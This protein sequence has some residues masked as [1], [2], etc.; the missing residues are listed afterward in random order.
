M[1]Y[2]L[3]AMSQASPTGL[4][5]DKYGRSIFICQSWFVTGLLLDPP[6]R[7]RVA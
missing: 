4:V 5:K 6:E 7:M 3:Y 2:A 1:N